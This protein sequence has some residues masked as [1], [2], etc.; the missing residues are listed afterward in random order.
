MTQLAKQLSNA[1]WGMVG[2]CGLL[3]LVPKFR[4]RAW[5]YAVAAG[6]AYTAVFVTEHIINRARPELLFPHEAIIRATQGGPGYPSGHMATLTALGLTLW[7]FVRWPWRVFIVLL[8]AAEAWA[9]IFLGVHT[10]LDIAGG[11]GIGLTAVAVLHLAPIKW[12]HFFKL[13]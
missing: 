12:R 6:G 11:V 9:R 3:L 4:L 13:A 7:L 2:L 5:Q 1:V 8:L 10:P